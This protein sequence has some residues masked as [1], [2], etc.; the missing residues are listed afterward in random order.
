[1]KIELEGSQLLCII[2]FLFVITL[3]LLAIKDQLGE[4]HK[5][6]KEDVEFRRKEQTLRPLLAPLK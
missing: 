5:T 2:T 6:I 3:S 1:M 4:I